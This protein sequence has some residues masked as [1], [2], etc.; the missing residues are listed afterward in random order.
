MRPVENHEP[1]Q[2]VRTMIMWRDG[3]SVDDGPLLRYDDPQN[4][5]HL[6]AINSG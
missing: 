5:A 2:V 1:E 6:E 3:F 4:R